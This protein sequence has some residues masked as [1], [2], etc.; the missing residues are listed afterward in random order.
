MTNSARAQRYDRHGRTVEHVTVDVTHYSQTVH[1]A[2]QGPKMLRTYLLTP[3]A[4]RALC[5]GMADAD[6]RPWR[7]AVPAD[8]EGS[9]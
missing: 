1:L 7:P 8:A 4:W 9:P 6:G 2:I 3:A 5:N